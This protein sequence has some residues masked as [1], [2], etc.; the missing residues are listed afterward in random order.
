MQR[1]DIWEKMLMLGKSEGK[2]RVQ[3]RLRRLDGITHSMDVS[4]GKPWEVVEDRVAWHAAVHEVAKSWAWFRD[5]TTTTQQQLVE[6]LVKSRL[7]FVTEFLSS[8]WKHSWVIPCGFLPFYFPQASLRCLF[9]LRPCCHCA[10]FFLQLNFRV[11]TTRIVI[12][13]YMWLLTFIKVT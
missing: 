5:W 11:G 1:A 4:L 13:I 2:R 6:A 7:C 9:Y 8:M 12:A 10:S 3:Q